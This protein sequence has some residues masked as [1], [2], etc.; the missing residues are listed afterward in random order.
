MLTFFLIVYIAQFDLAFFVASILAFHLASYLTFYSTSVYLAS[1]LVFFSGI[2]SGIYY[3]IFFPDILFC[4]SILSFYLAFHLK[5][6]SGIHLTH[7]DLA[8]AVE[9]R[10][11]P[12]R[13][14]ACSWVETCS[15]GEEGGDPHLAGGEKYQNPF[16]KF[17]SVYSCLFPV[18]GGWS[19]GKIE[20]KMVSAHAGGWMAK[21]G[22]EN[23]WREPT[24]LTE[25]AMGLIQVTCKMVQTHAHKQQS[26]VGMS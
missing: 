10:Q 2:L 25:T 23:C 12:L 21:L 13:S 19:T 8:L 7:W 24:L 16:G 4:H 15:L 14:G 3:L 1:I 6:H 5:F 11:C 17:I 18:L 22:S 26:R 20:K 9:V